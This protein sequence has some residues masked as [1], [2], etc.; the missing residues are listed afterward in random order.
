MGALAARVTASV[1]MTVVVASALLAAGCDAWR[2]FVWP[3]SRGSP[4]DPDASPPAPPS[5]PIPVSE[6]PVRL[7]P[8]ARVTTEDR[9]VDLLAQRISAAHQREQRLLVY[10]GSLA[11]RKYLELSSDPPWLL[12]ESI[13]GRR[14]GVLTSQG[15]SFDIPLDGWLS[16]A[17]H[18]P[19]DEVPQLA[20]AITLRSLAPK[21]LVTVFWEERPLANLSLSGGW[22][23]RTFSLPADLVR[24]GENRLRVYLRSAVPY[25]E[26]RASVAIE[27]IEVGP[28]EVIVSGPPTRLAA[29]DVLP[30]TSGDLEL[31]VAGGSSLVYHLELPRRARLAVDA[32]GAGRLEVWASTD[33]DH[34]L[35]R[36]PK[37]LLDRP[38]RATRNRHLVDLTGYAGVPARLEI[39]VHGNHARFRGLDL[40]A[41]RTAPVDRR[42]RSLR[43]VYVFAVEGA[44]ADLC[45]PGFVPRLGALERFFA[46]SMVFDRAYALGSAA[47]PSHAGWMSSVVPPNHLTVRGT[48]VAGS[49]IMLAESLDR[50]GFRNVGISANADVNDSRG[51][52]A[53]FGDFQHILRAPS[54][55][56]PASAVVERLVEQL[57]GH[58]GRKF[59]FVNLNDPQAP[60]V[61][62]P[63]L[64]EGVIPPQDAPARHLTHMWVGRV[65]LGKHEP[66][67]EEVTY[68][69]R[70]YRGELQLVDR[71]FARLIAAIDSEPVDPAP[72]VV[73][74]GVHGE[75]FLEHGGAGHGRTLFDESI[76]VPFA[77]RAPGLLAP[78]R[79]STPVDLLDLTPTLADLLGLEAA[80]TWQ[81]ESLVG[82]I[83]DPIPPPRLAVSHLGDGSRA[84]IVGRH[85]LILGPGRGRGAQ[86]YRELN[87]APRLDGGG[88]GVGLRI[89][90]NALTWHL[91]EEHRWRRTRWGT[92]ANLRPAFALDHGL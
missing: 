71:A 3:T 6:A 80:S 46:E 92:G 72:I 36:E 62:P 70:L 23:R 50:A 22:E 69:R 26:H 32:V 84:A 15:G 86:Q 7:A 89:V 49:Q 31:R 90:R 35:G 1:A 81:G 5:P 4:P 41:R 45:T 10:L 60:Y 16:P 39:R 79:V 18:P 88:D 53:G 2:S 30:G 27:S 8:V 58:D 75:E 76:H 44:R 73:F 17:L 24:V 82:V 52:T 43:D 9:W 78:G 91:W 65:R 67:L 14:A 47:V 85:K 40:E 83:D 20:M 74:L 37:R 55:T 13:G 34:R 51:L 61:P 42:A 68:V 12:G 66:S 29:Y 28:R 64:L 57:A 25:G 63:S 19:V 48:Y 59:G 56:S 21:Q 11:A 87:A 38:L 77:I 54:Q 33:A